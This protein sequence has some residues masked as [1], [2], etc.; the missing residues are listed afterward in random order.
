MRRWSIFGEPSRLRRRR[1]AKSPFY[2]PFAATRPTRSAAELG[3]LQGRARE[4]I[5]G[6]IT[7]PTAPSR[8]S[9]PRARKCRQTS[10][11]RR[12]PGQGILRGCRHHH[13]DLHARPDPR[14][15]LRKSRGIRAEMEAGREKGRLRE[16]RGDD[17]RHAHQSQIVRDDPEELMEATASVTKTIDGK[18]PACFRWLP[19]LPYGIRPMTAATAERHHRALPAGQPR[20]R[21]RRL[22]FRQ[23][24]EARPAAA[25]GN[26]AP[27]R[28][29]RRFP[30]TTCRSR[31]QQELDVPD[32]ADTSTSSPPSSK[33]GDSI[34]NGS[35]SRWACTTPRKRTWGA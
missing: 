10:A 19:R 11:S 9:R 26:P 4:V 3:A 32:G 17:R 23:H 22:L 20:K 33:A 13:D 24:V 31:C 21:H 7:A 25:V 8:R 15:G 12:C 5:G 35:A 14:I 2:G 16:P 34:R 18:M 28:C 1:P 6:P 30:A 27:C 29:T